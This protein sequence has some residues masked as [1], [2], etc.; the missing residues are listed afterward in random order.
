M[1]VLAHKRRVHRILQQPRGNA[2]LVGVGGSGRKSLSRLAT[3]IAEL[4]CFT[5]EITRN[6]RQVGVAAGYA[7]PATSLRSCL[8]REHRCRVTYAHSVGAHAHTL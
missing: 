2:L 3:F 1:H 8:L 4:K 7:C 5:I 6:Y